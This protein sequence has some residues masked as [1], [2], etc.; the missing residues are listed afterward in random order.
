MMAKLTGLLA[1]P[2]RFELPTAWF[3]E[4]KAEFSTNIINKVDGPP[5]LHPPSAALS[6]QIS[7]KGYAIRTDSYGLSDLFTLASSRPNR[8][9]L[10]IFKGW[11]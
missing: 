9:V 5:S 11:H 1:R 7:A 6:R 4:A 2:E 10:C 8:N 3:A